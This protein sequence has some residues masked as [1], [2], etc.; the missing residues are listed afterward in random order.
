MLDEFIAGRGRVDELYT[1]P[2]NWQDVAVLAEGE[3]RTTC[4]LVPG[5]TSRAGGASS[6][7]DHP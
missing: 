6:G 1:G 5:A 3:A 7:N 4:S 2:L